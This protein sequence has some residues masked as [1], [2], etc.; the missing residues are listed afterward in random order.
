MVL[1]ILG[2]LVFMS[3]KTEHMHAVTYIFAILDARLLC[4]DNAWNCRRLLAIFIFNWL[5]AT[6]LFQ[7]YR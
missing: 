3:V 5:M 4:T 1:Q 6:R 7:G 2:I